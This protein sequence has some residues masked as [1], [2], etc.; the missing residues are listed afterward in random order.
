MKITG[1]I[2]DKIV[3]DKKKEVELLKHETS[4]EVLRDRVMK[5]SREVRDF[6][7]ALLE[8]KKPAIIG[9]LKKASPSQGLIRPDFDVIKLAKDYEAS[10]SVAAL[11]ILTEKNYF[12]G[13]IT[14]LKQVRDVV[15][16]PLLRKDFIFDTYQVYESFL[17]GADAILLIVTM[18]EEEK[19]L[20]LLQTANQLGLH[21]LVEVHT[22]EELN[23]ALSSGAKIIGINSRDL[24]TFTFQK[25]LFS[26]LVT[27][28]PSEIIKVAESGIENSYDIHSLKLAGADAVLVG[29]SIMKE[30][31]IVMKLKDLKGEVPYA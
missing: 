23:I 21:V 24:K 19:L 10:G 5:V 31:N 14:Y 8:V 29:T 25:N 12:Q 4:E 26:Q 9:E 15:G 20:M 30:K 16:L 18:L 3:A 2:L 22:H 27:I 7:S 28:I 6:A 1:S 13:D 11:S 17:A